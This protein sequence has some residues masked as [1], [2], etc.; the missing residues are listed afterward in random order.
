MWD[1]QRE[2]SRAEERLRQVRE[3]DDLGIVD[4]GTPAH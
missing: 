4:R 2:A 3:T 1:R